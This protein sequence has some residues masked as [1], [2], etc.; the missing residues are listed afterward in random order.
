MKLLYR[1][2][3]TLF[4]SNS[5]KYVLPPKICERIYLKI[6]KFHSHKM[7]IGCVNILTLKC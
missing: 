3:K 5:G 2:C 4:D 7:Q 6:K 1:L